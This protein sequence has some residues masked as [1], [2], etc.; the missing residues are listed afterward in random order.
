MHALV[1]KGFCKIIFTTTTLLGIL[2]YT[3]A[4]ATMQLNTTLNARCSPYDGLF[5]SDRLIE[6][7]FAMKILLY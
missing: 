2:E 5:F 6:G 4:F 1:L 7:L 3:K